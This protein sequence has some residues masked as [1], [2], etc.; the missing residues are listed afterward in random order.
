MQLDA[1]KGG[2]IEPTEDGS[3]SLERKHRLELVIGNHAVFFLR[4]NLGSMRGNTEGKTTS[5]RHTLEMAKL[6]LESC[7]F[8]GGAESFIFLVNRFDHIVSLEMLTS[9][10]H[11]FPLELLPYHMS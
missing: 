10:F 11:V 3:Y 2:K 6:E 7:V 1:V 5:K 4:M 9:C 8:L